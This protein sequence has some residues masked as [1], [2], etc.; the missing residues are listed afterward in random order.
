[1]AIKAVSSQQKVVEEVFFQNDAVSVC[2]LLNRRTHTLRIVDFRAGPSAAKRLFVLSVAQREGMA[3]MFTLVE[4]DEAATWVKMGFTKEGNIPGFYKRSDAFLLGCVVPPPG[5]A[6]HAPSE[7]DDAPSQSETRIVAA[8]ASPASNGA[9]PLSRAQETMERTLLVAKKAL[10]DGPEKALPAAKVATVTE[11]ETR[12]AVAAAL[13]SGRALTAFEP[14]G[15]D[16]ER[17]Y[18]LT[19]TRGG[20]DLYASTEAQA[21]FGNAFLELLQGPRTE[22]EGLATAGALRA[23]CEK[24]LSEGVVS[25]FSLAPSDDVI[26]ASAFLQNGFR[27]TGLLNEQWPAHDGTPARRRRKDVILWSRKLANPGTE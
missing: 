6:A 2:L 25:C 22:S 24:L 5:A 21:C 9:T 11:G 27:R 1:M 4:R 17:R 18:F 8:G 7:A 10:K 19:T 3:K 13:R 20:F 15:R 12:K 23:L 14:F 16:V 26:L